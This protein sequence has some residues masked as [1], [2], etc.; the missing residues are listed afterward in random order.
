VVLVGAWLAIPGALAS[1]QSLDLELLQPGPSEGAALGVENAQV[2]LK[3]S[4][5]IGVVTQYQASPLVLFEEGSQTGTVVGNRLR[6][7]VV[8]AVSMS[9][10]V[11]LQAAIPAALQWGSTSEDFAA[12]GFGMGDAW[13]GVRANVL[14]S[15]PVD[16]AVRG[17]VVTPSGRREAW[18]GET[19]ARV[20][21]G[22]LARYAGPVG[23]GLDVGL[24]TRDTFE[25]QPDLDLVVGPE[26]GFG[27]TVD[28]SL[29]DLVGVSVTGLGRTALSGGRGVSAM[30][31][32]AGV[33]LTPPGAPRVDLGAGRGFGDGYGSTDL[34]V[35]LGLTWIDDTE[36]PKQPEPVA[37]APREFDTDLPELVAEPEPEPEPEAK[38][39]EWGEQEL[40]RVE[41]AN[42]VVRDPIRF[43]AG[44]VKVVAESLPTLE[45]VAGLVG[46]DL[47]I[48]EGHASE[49]GEFGFNYDLSLDRA[50]AIYEE[51]LRAGVPAGQLSYRGLGEVAPTQAGA[52]EADLAAN[53]RVVFY[54]VRLQGDR[55]A[56]P[57]GRLPW[58]GEP[59]P[60][61]PAGGAQ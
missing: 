13:I 51:L 30:E 32:L 35:V 26:A 14:A 46:D 12:D 48:I 3:G 4:T 41:G 28:R 22:V 7:D 8:G 9:D 34:R 44:T 54:L 53:R 24:L 61:R 10:R 56:A 38:E 17:A 5:R 60:A 33:S 42:I 27:L 39:P 2:P 11:A 40:A 43:E 47:L 58:S 50:R 21:A 55:G 6:F 31:A 59:Q 15:G 20:R 1:G 52:A 49:E 29:S 16:L 57:P 37:T 36:P 45:Q 23:V 19:K 18:M 25:T